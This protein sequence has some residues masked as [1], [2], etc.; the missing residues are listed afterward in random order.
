MSDTTI[1]QAG[2]TLVTGINVFTLPPERHRAL[3]ETLEAINQEIIKHEYPMNVTSNFHRAVDAPIVINYNQYTDRESGTHLRTRET[4][5]PLM[6]RT[7]D[8]SDGH[9]MRWY[10]VADVVTPAD[11][12]DRIEITDDR[13]YIGVIGIFTVD[14]DKQ[15][16]FLDRLKRYGDAVRSAR[17]F[18]GMA[19]HRGLVAEHVASY[20]IW[21]SADAYKQATALPAIAE[22]LQE[23]RADAIATELHTYDVVTVTRFN[24]GS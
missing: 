24:E 6:K 4:V 20:E 8:L 13:G 23:L 17:G 2:S 16:E 12:A 9:E 7:H 14:G 18:R 11:P 15:A 21:D 3:I 5:A 1:V 22:A 10:Q 19:T